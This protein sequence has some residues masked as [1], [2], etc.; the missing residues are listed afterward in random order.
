MAKPLI[1]LTIFLIPLFQPVFGF[2][3]EQIKVFVF[4]VLTSVVGLLWIKDHLR[5]PKLYRFQYSEIRLSAIIFLLVLF[6]SSLKSDDPIS[7]LIGK[8]PYY[9]GFI[10]Y[11]YLLLF[12]IFVSI[13]QVSFVNISKTLTAASFFVALF[14]I[15]DLVLYKFLNQTIALYSDRII[16][17]FGQP[18]FYAGFLLICLPFIFYLTSRPGN[19]R[20]NSWKLFG[21]ITLLL[22][23]LSIGISQSRSALVLAFLSVYMTIIGYINYKAKIS[24]VIIGI[25]VFSGALYFSFIKSSGLIYR[26]YIQPTVDS[27]WLIHNSPEK[28]VLIWPITTILIQER[29]VLGY[30][31][32]GMEDAW[33]KYFRQFNPEIGQMSA[34]NFTLKDL[35]INSSHNYLLDLLIFSGILGLFGW[36]TLVGTALKALF[37]LNPTRYTILMALLLYILFV[38]LQNQSLVHLLLF[39]ILIGLI[40][41]PT[42]KVN[43]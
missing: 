36:L 15:K 29:P 40:D 41:N 10:L 3:Y 37:P 11:A 14:A 31:L 17:T 16:S 20:L 32:S 21:A 43:H 26:E 2:G 4:L 25:L 7:S 22:S 12:G 35:Y 34:L 39:W 23:I 24:L 42:Q 9:Q 18:N 27:E 1:L 19:V 38:Q 28:R 8:Q 6:I 33:T 13:Y 30:G 5:Q